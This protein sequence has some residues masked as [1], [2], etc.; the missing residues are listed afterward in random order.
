MEQVKRL[1]NIKVPLLNMARILNEI[2]PPVLP[3]QLISPLRRFH[4]RLRRLRR[5]PSTRN[6]PRSN[7]NALLQRFQPHRA[8]DSRQALQAL[9]REVHD[10]LEDGIRARAFAV[11]EALAV[12]VG[13]GD[14]VV[15]GAGHG[16]GGAELAAGPEAVA[17]GGV[18]VVAAEALLGEDGVGLVVGFPGCF[19]AGDGGGGVLGLGEEGSGEDHREGAGERES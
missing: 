15:A 7:L 12:G 14:C 16:V 19:A 9:G 2:R 13:R 4:N 1:A 5:R 17:G 11:V 18:D 10:C 8:S 6:K 3:T